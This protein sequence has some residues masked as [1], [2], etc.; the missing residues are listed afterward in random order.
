MPNGERGLNMRTRGGRG[1]C[2][3]VLAI[4][5]IIIFCT[6]GVTAETETPLNTFEYANTGVALAESGNYEDAVVYYNKALE[7][8]P[9]IAETHYNKAV[10]LEH[11]GLREQAISEY[12]T[13]IELDPNFIEA[14][15][16]LFI[17]TMDVINP[18][19][20]AVAVLGG[21]VLVVSYYRHKKKEEMKK[22]VMQG[23]SQDCH[24][25]H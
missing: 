22:R 19:T 2:Y 7:L 5:G 20:I 17:L 24:S 21:C 16:N 11:L 8:Y 4:L 13:A 14:Q 9:D 3:T 12:E 18:V 1:G 15:T 10:A 25:S 23:I 6:G